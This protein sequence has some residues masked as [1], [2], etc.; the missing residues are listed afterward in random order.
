MALVSLYVWWNSLSW[1]IHV[2]FWS[3][4]LF[5]MSVLL[6]IHH[7]LHFL[8]STDAAVLFYPPFRFFLN[9]FLST[10]SFFAFVPLSQSLVST[11]YLYHFFIRAL[12]LAFHILWKTSLKW[13]FLFLYTIIFVLF[14]L[15]NVCFAACSLTFPSSCCHVFLV[16]VIFHMYFLPYFSLTFIF[17]FPCLIFSPLFLFFS[18]C[19]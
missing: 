3:P 12:S 14:C 9:L 5:L 15:A 1:L 6:Y 16:D 18:T 13:I 19:S 11:F 17:L 10:S 4:F 7:N 2:S 8:F